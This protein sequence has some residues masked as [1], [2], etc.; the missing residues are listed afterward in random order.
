MK[1]GIEK[2]FYIYFGLIC[3]I[4]FIDATEFN[5][6]LKTE[7]NFKINLSEKK[8][9]HRLKAKKDVN[10]AILGALSTSSSSDSSVADDLPAGPVYFKGWIKFIHFKT[11]K[12]SEEF[13]KHFYQNNEFYEQLKHNITVTPQGSASDAPST[14]AAASANPNAVKGP[15]YFY[16]MLFKDNLN[17]ISSPRNNLKTTFDTLAIDKIKP[18]SEKPGFEVKNNG[19]QD[20]GNF[21]EGYCFKVLYEGDMNW[22]ICSDTQAEKNNLMMR[23]KQL[24]LKHQQEDGLV[25]L[26]E[27][28]APAEL[29]PFNPGKGSSPELEDGTVKFGS[30]ANIKDGYWVVLQNWTP[31]SLKCGGG[32]STLQRMC[33]PPKEGGKECDGE[34]ILTKKCNEQACPDIRKTKEANLT[35]AETEPVHPT[36]KILPFSSR[37]QRYTVT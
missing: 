25:V 28:I 7:S 11:N 5:T 3:L 2:K 12:N 24:K 18:V 6:H 37:P 22:I 32:T 10:E 19:L 21:S 31:C 36:V 34:A 8:M 17:F 23:L 1:F 35:K 33:V 27:E 14:D 4:T 16:C 30:D 9:K 15:Q 20:F 26:P 13:P 29:N